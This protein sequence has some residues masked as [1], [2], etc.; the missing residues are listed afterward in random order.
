MATSKAARRFRRTIVLGVLCLATLIWAAT[1][2]FGIAPRTMLNLGLGTLLGALLIIVL[3]AVFVAALKGLR[4]LAAGRE[5]EDD[6][7][8]GEG[9]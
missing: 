3:A 2:Q 7:T 4:R 5:S 9:G 8:D 6:I 1:E